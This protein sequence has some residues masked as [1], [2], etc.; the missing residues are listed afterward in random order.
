[1][2]QGARLGIKIPPAEVRTHPR[3][4]D[5]YEWSILPHSQHLFRQNLS[6]LTAREYIQLIQGVGEVFEAVHRK[7][8]ST[9]LYPQNRVGLQQA[10][11]SKVDKDGETFTSNIE[12]LSSE[13]ATLQQEA[14]LLKAAAETELQ[15]RAQLETDLKRVR[16]AYIVLRKENTKS[17]NDARRLGF[18]VRAL[19]VK[20]QESS[21]G[22]R[23]IANFSQRLEERS[24]PN[25]IVSQYGK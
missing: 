19:Q 8:D 20:I 12:R 11:H 13:I 4:D 23:K 3:A 2:C 16:A 22:I 18:I 25:S 7:Q 10:C 14:S 24:K 9:A 6:K 17:Q 5:D 21:R 15:A 1:M